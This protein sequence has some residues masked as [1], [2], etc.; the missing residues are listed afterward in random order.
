MALLYGILFDYLFRLYIHL[1]YFS[2]APKSYFAIDFNDPAKFK[3]SSKGVQ[4]QVRLQYENYRNTLYTADKLTV[5]NKSIRLRNNQ[6][7]TMTVKK[8]GL[9]TTFVKGYVD[10]DHITVTP[11]R[12]FAEIEDCEDEF[13]CDEFALP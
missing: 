9:S 2:L 7:T 11:F 1:N 8:V 10:E 12:R 13:V 3:R 6:M 4:H 5:Q